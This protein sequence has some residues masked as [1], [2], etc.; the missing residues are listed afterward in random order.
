MREGVRTDQPV[1]GSIVAIVL[2]AGKASRMG[3]AGAHKLLSEFD[4]VPLVR[5]TAQVALDSKV[6]PVVLVTGH[7]A[8]EIAAALEDMPIRLLHNP[9]FGTGMASSLITGVT[10]AMSVDA[11]AAMIVLA[12]MPSVT[13]AHIAQMADIFCRQD[14][15]AIVRAHGAGRNGN[16]VILPRALF[17]QILQLRGDVGARDIIEASHLP[18]IPVDIGSAASIDVNTAA[19]V[20]AAGGIIRS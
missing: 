15:P 3:S 7:R 11:A 10:S 6:G 20:V 12:D 17:G 5:R 1:A 9:D 18:V 4:G 8:P 16:P 2:A 14:G 13:S 19:D